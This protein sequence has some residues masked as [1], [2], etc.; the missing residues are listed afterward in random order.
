MTEKPSGADG[1]GSVARRCALAVA[2]IGCSSEGTP[3]GGTG[4]TPP[5]ANSTP[6]V[7]SALVPELLGP[8]DPGD[9]GPGGLEFDPKTGRF[10]YPEAGPP[11]PGNLL[12]Q[13]KLPADELG[14]DEQIGVVLEAQFLP[15]AIPAPPQAPEVNKA[16][17]AAAA[18]LTAPNVIITAT[19]LGR[20]KVVFDSRALPMP[21]HSELRSRFDR[22]GHLALWPSSSKYRVLPPG[23]LRTALGERRVDVTPLSPGVKS[24]AGTGKRLELPTR[25]ITLDSALGQVHLELATVSESG[26]GGPLLCRALVETMGIDPATSECKPEELPLAAS[27]DWLD[28]GGLDFEVVSLERKMDM[29]PGEVLVPTP[30]AELATEG[31]PDASDGVYLSQEEL[32]AFRKQAAQVGARDP[33]APQEGFLADNGRDFAMTLL[34]DGVPVVSVPAGEKR[35][36]LGTQPGR[37]TVQWRTFLGDRIEAAET[38]ELPA[39]LR[40]APLPPDQDA[41]PPGPAPTATP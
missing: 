22:Y 6:S 2:L 39:L 13:T 24:K 37:Y 40:S 20:M 16:G 36:M 33:G 12:A 31:L 19:A 18:K 4:E 7:M 28:G 32:G 23:A 8:T 10:I 14:R 34:I 27:F 25:S 21:Y 15:R 30:N 26:L 41:G 29:P 5:L 1:R 3:T 35:L 17:I 9:A 38:A 11:A